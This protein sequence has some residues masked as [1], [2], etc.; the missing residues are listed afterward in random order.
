LATLNNSNTR[1]LK[2]L[3]KIKFYALL[4][5][6]LILQAKVF[7]NITVALVAPVQYTVIDSVFDVQAQIGNTINY[8]LPYIKA[9]V[10]D[11]ETDLTWTGNNGIFKGKLN[12]KG[13]PDNDTL[14]LTVTAVGFNND[15]V[16]SSIQIIHKVTPYQIIISFISPA[17]NALIE[18]TLNVQVSLGNTI[19]SNVPYIVAKVLDRQVNL[20]WTGTD[21]IFTGQLNLQGLPQ[22]DTLA[23]SVTAVGFNNDT[24]TALQQIIHKV[25]P[26]L[27][28]LNNTSIALPSLRVI[29]NCT[30]YTGPCVIRVYRDS[31]TTVVAEA[32]NSINTVVDCQPT[33]PT[34]FLTITG[35]DNTG[36]VTK[37]IVN[38]TYETDTHFNGYYVL[39]NFGGNFTDVN[40]D[41]IL[42]GDLN[43]FDM[44]SGSVTPID[45]PN[46]YSNG[47]YFEGRNIISIKLTKKGALIYAQEQ[48]MDKYDNYFPLVSYITYN[49]QTTHVEYN[50][51]NQYFTLPGVVYHGSGNPPDGL[52]Y[53]NLSTNETVNVGNLHMMAATPNFLDISEQEVIGG[54]V[55]GKIYYYSKVTGEKLI[56]RSAAFTAPPPGWGQRIYG[57][58]ASGN[59]I[60]YI[61]D[62]TNHSYYSFDGITE[63]KIADIDNSNLNTFDIA[64]RNGYV[65]FNINGSAYVSDAYANIRQINGT[66]E[67][68]DDSGGVVYQSGGYR[69]FTDKNGN[70]RLKT[71][72]LY[73]KLYSFG[74][75]WYLAYNNVVY[76]IIL[77]DILPLQLT[78]FTGQ[79][80]GAVNQLNW[81]T[82]QEVNTSYF[83]VQHS[84]STSPAFTP[85]GQV[86]AAGNNSVMQTYAYSHAKPP[87]GINYYRLKMVDKDGKFTYSKTISITNGNVYFNAAVLP[88]PVHNA[89]TLQISSGISQKVSVNIVSLTGAVLATKQF[90]V[91]AGVNTK[92][93]AAGNLAKGTY[94]VKVMAADK[95]QA[96]LQVVKQ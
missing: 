79:N 69:Y 76:K 8:S 43:I 65:I 89:I 61:T 77:N 24:V 81:Q 91:S 26:N 47:R 6:L 85:L 34:G 93:I 87:A 80:N 1:H 18:N 25:T 50:F 59:A 51:T 44:P 2:I 22:I 60:F 86:K 49:G 35:T 96:T 88:N 15:T 14:T 68:L 19:H 28:Y 63:H 95:T 73:G 83:E 9:K 21:A 27:Q 75:D 37:M 4:T 11:R 78:A 20:T 64:A 71:D 92:T 13:L 82:A 56:N 46:I 48:Y 38:Y 17:A 62:G 72:R 52:S 5:A 23:L 70:I 42:K 16:T 66:L 10:Q 41:K 74:G 39:D 90:D 54:P 94:F 55:D 58:H 57:F 53:V 67:A 29:A 31:G 45:I 33:G 30:A 3:M 12:L 40:F 84:T 7:A 32:T 36:L